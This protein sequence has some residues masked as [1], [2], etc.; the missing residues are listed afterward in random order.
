MSEAIK[1]IPEKIVSQEKDHDGEILRGQNKK[2]KRGV[3]MYVFVTYARANMRGVQVR[4]IRVANNLPRDKVF[5]IN[6]GDN[7]WLKKL[8][9]H[10]KNFEFKRFS[11]SLKF[12]FPKGTK[13]VIFCDLPT[14]RP[15][16][17]TILLAAQ[18]EKLPVIVLEN[19]YRKNQF[20]EGVYR[21]TLA[22]ADAMIFNGLSC[23]W[24]N[25][26]VNKCFFVSP[27]IEQYPNQD[28]KRIELLQKFGIQKDYPYVLATGYDKEVLNLIEKIAQNPQI[29]RLNHL[30]L[31]AGAKQEL[32]RKKN[33]VFL[34][35]LNEEEMSLLLSEAKLLISKGGY[36]QINEALLFKV[37]PIVVGKKSG[38]RHHWLDSRL[39][40]VI[41]YFPHIDQKIIE[42]VKTLL[43]NSPLR[44]KLIS[45][46]SKLHNCQFNGAKKI[47]K[48]ISNVKFEPKITDKKLL[49]CLDKQEEL[50]KAKQIIQKEPFILPIF[51]N[52][53]FFT[54]IWQ[55]SLEDYE[56]KT[57]EVLQ[58]NIDIVYNF[59]HDSL[60]GFTK[61]FPWHDIFWQ[62]LKMLIGEA[63]MIYIIGRET[64]DFLQDLIKEDNKKI[65]IVEDPSFIYNLRQK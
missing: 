53:S 24:P 57:K 38:Y 35:M 22:Y 6:S 41:S 25:K 50:K 31:I 39:Q 55:R 54:D 5:F 17:T 32:E 60:H 4:G 7:S 27:L 61:I 45:E 43:Q 42:K 49:I 26:K 3:K 9:F 34:P 63:D 37:P 48:I 29:S 14:N 19:I 30:F 36:L 58:Q 12:Q 16:Q 10:F 51:I 18:R 21:N 8:G 20:R 15:F 62:N 11:P 59:S 1:S 2:P 65:K 56:V 28:R 33:I 64:Y 46:I 44:K 52:M 23:L 40:S 47:A 13:A